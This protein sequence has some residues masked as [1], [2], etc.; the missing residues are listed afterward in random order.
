[1]WPRFANIAFGLWLMA[2]PAVFGYGPPAATSDYIVG[3]LVAAFACIAIWEAMRPM[4]WLNLPLGIWLLASPWLMGHPLGG[5]IN[6]TVIGAA[7]IIV[8][9]LGGQTRRRF[10]GGWSSLWRTSE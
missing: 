6:C 1:M 3:P 9:C 4:R 10:A 7:V 2:A 8:S 5:Q